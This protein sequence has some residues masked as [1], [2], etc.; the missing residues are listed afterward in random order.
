M[1]AQQWVENT[2]AREEAREVDPDSEMVSSGQGGG[3]ITLPG[4]AVLVAKQGAGDQA[5]LERGAEPPDVSITLSGVQTSDNGVSI[6][7]CNNTSST[8]VT[9]VP[10]AA[11]AGCDPP[12]PGVPPDL[13]SI[14]DSMELPIALLPT[15]LAVYRDVR[16]THKILCVQ[17]YCVSWSTLLTARLRS[18]WPGTSLTTQSMDSLVTKTLTAAGHAQIT[19]KTVH[20]P[21]PVIPAAKI[22]LEL[23]TRIQDHVDSYDRHPLASWKA[24]HGNDEVPLSSRQFV[25]LGQF[26]CPPSDTYNWDDLMWQADLCEVWSGLSSVVDKENNND[27]KKTKRQYRRVNDKKEDDNVSFNKIGRWLKRVNNIGSV[28]KFERRPRLVTNNLRLFWSNEKVEILKQ[29]NLV[30]FDKWRFAKHRKYANL[31]NLIVDEFKS[32]IT[33][34]ASNLSPGQILG[35]LS[36]IQRVGR[37]RLAIAESREWN[38]YVTEYNEFLENE[39]D[40]ET[41]EY[42]DSVAEKVVKREFLDGEVDYNIDANV[43]DYIREKEGGKKSAAPVWGSSSLY[44]LLKARTLALARRDKWEKWAVA[45]HGSLQVAVSNPRVKVP[46]VEE[47]LME[48]WSQLRPNMSGISAWTLN[49]YLKKFDGVKRTLIEDQ[50]EARRLRELRAAPPVRMNCHPNTDI[51]IY[52]LSQLETY[53]KLPA[54]VKQ[55]IGSRQRAL[56][57]QPASS[58]RYLHLWAEQWLQETG[59]RT[60]GWMLQ[61][62]LHKLQSSLSV[63]NKL[64]KFAEILE[65]EAA[66]RNADIDPLSFEYEDPVVAPRDSMF[67]RVPDPISDMLIRRKHEEVDI[68]A[69]DEENLVEVLG[70]GR[71]GLPVMIS[72]ND[73][74]EEDGL[75]FKSKMSYMDQEGLSQEEVIAAKLEDSCE[76]KGYQ[77]FNNVNNFTSYLELSRLPEQEQEDV[78]TFGQKMA[79]FWLCQSVV[80]DCLNKALLSAEEELV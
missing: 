4:G 41:E 58:L 80:S 71:L 23:L 56:T 51:P 67:P 47:L 1:L 33:S 60:E 48:E 69:Y 2:Q 65:G 15:L 79:S 9:P 35:K 34:G 75:V 37:S 74:I 73:I 70:D 52:K 68:L 5:R 46:K 29:S 49:S 8:V 25:S 36:Q 40:I 6:T 26:L 50:E 13:L 22:S 3:M 7:L 78:P 66:E 16:D 20:R 64:R 38:K 43:L 18:A 32:R 17:G 27:S 24:W 72:I 31:K 63:R 76:P 44:F 45:K 30:A 10:A 61:Q 77:H 54:N 14:L 59:E 11:P 55:L 28:K 19:C 39:A 12:A 21:G 62:R 57:S 53:P 42:V